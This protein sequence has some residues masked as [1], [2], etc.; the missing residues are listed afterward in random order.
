M[1]EETTGTNATTENS[2]IRD[3]RAEIDRSKQAERDA[4]KAVQ[5]AASRAQKAED[6]L[7]ARERE[8]MEEIDR[9]KAENEDALNKLKEAQSAQSERD[10][11]A[12]TLEDT[13]NVKLGQVT[14]EH[15]SKVEALSKHGNWAER[16]AAIDAAIGLLPTPQKVDTGGGATVTPMAIPDA[17]GNNNGTEQQVDLSAIGKAGGTM[18]SAWKNDLTIKP[19]NE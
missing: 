19:E 17:G 15:R 10:A 18:S 7:K 14:E 8:D 16:C 2:T 11:Y 9:L 12:K 5:D 6:A 3:M 4:E 1:S 13:Y